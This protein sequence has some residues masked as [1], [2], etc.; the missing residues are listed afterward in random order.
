MTSPKPKHTMNLT[1]LK[2]LSIQFS[3]SMVISL[4]FHSH[5]SIRATLPP[6][7]TKHNTFMTT[8]LIK[9]VNMITAMLNQ[10]VFPQHPDFP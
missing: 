9:T 2:Y 5:R 1:H 7:E 4:V 6:L 8:Q 10:K 3:L